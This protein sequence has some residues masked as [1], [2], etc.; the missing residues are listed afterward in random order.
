MQSP[1]IW[2]ACSLLNLAATNREIEILSSMGRQSYVPEKVLRDEVLYLRPFEQRDKDE[3]ELIDP[4]PL[5]VAGVL[6]PLVLSSEEYELYVDF[7]SQVDDGEAQCLAIAASRSYCLASDDGA[8]LRVA[9]E[10]TP[11]ISVITTPEWLQTWLNST[12]NVDCRV[13]VQMVTKRAK[14]RPRRTSALLSWWQ[15]C[16]E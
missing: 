11:A 5:V 3:L 9:R 15:S 4:Q 16:L 7:A 8:A 6:T 2:D 1:L 14:F 13:V 10:W 12:P